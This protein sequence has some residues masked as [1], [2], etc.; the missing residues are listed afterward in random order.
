[1][2]V[3]LGTNFDYHTS[4]AA[5]DLLTDEEINQNNLPELLF[6]S[7]NNKVKPCKTYNFD[8]QALPFDS[9]SSLFILH[10]NISSLQAHFDELNEFLLNFPNPPAIIFLSETRINIAPQI[11]NVLPGYTFIHHPSPTR[12]GGVGAYIK[13]SLIF[14]IKDNLSLNVQGCEDLWISIDFPGL[15]SK[16]VF[17]VIYHHPCSNHNAFFDNLEQNM[18]A[19]NDKKTKVMIMGDINIDLASQTNYV[20]D[21]NLLLQSNFF[22]SLITKPTRVT[23]SSKTI[24][25][26]VLTNDTDSIL[27][28]GILTYS[29][30][31]HYPIFCTISNPTFKTTKKNMT[32]SFRNIALVNGDKFRSDLY[33]VLLPLFDKLIHSYSN[34]TANSFNEH[35][36]KMMNAIFVVIN[37]HAPLQNATRKQKR[38]FQKPW[39]TKGLIT[40]IKRKQRLYKSHL[41]KR[42]FLR[43]TIL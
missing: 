27:T 29:I 31:D 22:F 12:A 11:S 2:V 32:Y 1:M 10:L 36:N 26:H 13:S 42:E 15:K 7:L 43:K 40:S 3:D 38:L 25:D 20:S 41:F 16:Y 17:S 5:V 24:I 18:Q 39:I 14:S 28:P 19:L 9:P 33:S 35:F 21:Y 34:I 6:H 8:N 30:S 23:Y 37:L 4:Q